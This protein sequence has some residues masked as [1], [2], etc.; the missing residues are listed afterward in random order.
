MHPWLITSPPVPAYGVLILVGF[1]IAWIWGRRRAQRAGLEVSQFDLLMPVLLGAGLLGAWWFG[2]MTD[3]LTGEDSESAVLV[4]SLLVATAAGI[5]YAVFN[6]IKLGVL[7]DV[8]A[9]PLAL[10]IGIGRVG[11]FMA[12][13]CFGKVSTGATWLTAV[14][15]PAGSF[16]YLQQMRDGVLPAGS[17]ESLGVFP[18]QLYEAA[19]CLLLA[20][21]VSAV[22][23]LGKKAVAGERFLAMGLGYAVIRFATEFFRG[24]NPLIA[25][26]TFSQWNALLIAAATLTTWYIRRRFAEPLRLMGAESTEGSFV[27]GADGV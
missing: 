25:G 15:F 26:L 7:G 1:L 13:C 19:L 6:R 3:A 12:G 8:C 23:R 16:A 14:H 5:G 24:D 18:V 21:M 9:G 10:G 20:W 2:H 27:L 4:G 17:R 11:C 22:P